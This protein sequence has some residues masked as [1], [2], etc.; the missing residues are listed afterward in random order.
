VSDSIPEVLGCLQH[1]AATG[2]GLFFGVQ[3]RMYSTALSSLH[4]SADATLQAVSL[5]VSAIA[6]VD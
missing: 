2:G 5:L 1:K 6:I 3:F 4:Y